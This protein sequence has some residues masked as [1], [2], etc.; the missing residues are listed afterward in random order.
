MRSSSVLV[1]GASRNPSGSHPDFPTACAVAPS[2]PK[3]SDNLDLAPELRTKEQTVELILHDDTSQDV[4]YM[5]HTF[6]KRGL[7]V[8]EN[9]GDI[10]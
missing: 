1:S 10:A 9:S 5:H 4:A 7:I 2:A 3:P 6:Q 8:F